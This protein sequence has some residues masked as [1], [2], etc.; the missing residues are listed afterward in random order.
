MCLC[1]CMHVS[2]FNKY[3]RGSYGKTMLSCCHLTREPSKTLQRIRNRVNETIKHN[4]RISKLIYEVFACLYFC[5]L[6]KC[7]SNPYLK[8]AYSFECMSYNE[9]LITNPDTRGILWLYKHLVGVRL[10]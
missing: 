1:V 3:P 9:G 5:S 7:S 4:C 8:L 2:P 6:G 10:L